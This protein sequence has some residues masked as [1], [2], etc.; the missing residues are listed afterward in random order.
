MLLNTQYHQLSKI[1]NLHGISVINVSTERLTSDAP[2]NAPGKGVTSNM[3]S[4]RNQRFTKYSVFW[5]AKTTPYVMTSFVRHNVI[6]ESPTNGF[7]IRKITHVCHFLSAVPERAV[8]MGD[9]DNYNGSA[10]SM[11]WTPVEDTREMLKGRL[12]GYRVGWTRASRVIAF[13]RILF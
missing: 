10:F 13:N 12:K 9:C 3:A 7:W 8:L 11:S 2:T 1:N 6:S 4:A 5:F